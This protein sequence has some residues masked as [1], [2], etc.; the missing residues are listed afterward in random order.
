MQFATR[1][2]N[3]FAPLL[4]L[5]ISIKVLNM[6]LLMHRVAV[7]SC[8]IIRL[9]EMGMLFLLL[10]KKL[11]DEYVMA[12]YLDKIDQNEFRI[13]KKDFNMLEYSLLYRVLVICRVMR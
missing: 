5:S 8:V 2:S 6:L 7:Q 1:A 4:A 9:L 13:S 12:A 11:A 3:A 10:S